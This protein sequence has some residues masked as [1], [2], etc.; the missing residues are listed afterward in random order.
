MMGEYPDLY[1]DATNVLACFRPEFKP[2]LSLV[3]E[4]EKIMDILIEGLYKYRGRVMFGS[5]HPAGMGAL[6]RIY[7]DLEELPVDYEIKRDLKGD[8][9][10]AFIERFKPGF[11]W[12]GGL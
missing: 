7:Q 9:A 11:N 8:A 10:L 12:D 3:P 4:G 2:M 1:L 5:D 6:G